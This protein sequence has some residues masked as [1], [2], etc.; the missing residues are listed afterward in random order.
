MLI[1]MN[2]NREILKLYGHN[3]ILYDKSYIKLVN[4]VYRRIFINCV[5]IITF[6][7][8]VSKHFIFILRIRNTLIL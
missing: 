8:M 6:Q 2:I 1:V 7:F 5:A 4:K 3:N